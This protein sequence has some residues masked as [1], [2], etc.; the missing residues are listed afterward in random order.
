MQAAILDGASAQ[1]MGGVEAEALGEFD[2]RIPGLLRVSA[3]HIASRS[4]Q[5]KHRP[6]K[7]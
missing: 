1:M 4:G 5:V 3:G 2:H 6:E 7:A